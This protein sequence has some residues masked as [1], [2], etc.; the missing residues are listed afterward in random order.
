MS[1]CVRKTCWCWDGGLW[2]WVFSHSVL[3]WS[4]LALAVVVAGAIAVA[5]VHS[6]GEVI[7]VKTA[8]PIADTIQGCADG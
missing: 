1:V 5:V 4:Y 2:C 8:L 7:I 6:K 3:S